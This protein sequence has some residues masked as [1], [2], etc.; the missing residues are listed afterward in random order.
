MWHVAGVR[1]ANAAITG[2]TTTWNDVTRIKALNRYRMFL[3]YGYSEQMAWCQEN[4]DGSS[5]NDIKT[6]DGGKST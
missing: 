4:D 1:E 5:K 3:P 6:M 2:Y